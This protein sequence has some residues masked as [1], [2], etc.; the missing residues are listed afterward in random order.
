MTIDEAI[1]KLTAAKNEGV[2]SVVMAYW[3]SNMF[4]REDGAPLPDDKEWEGITEA[5]EYQMDWSRTHDDLSMII[6]Q[7]Y[8][9]A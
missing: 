5:V 8:E 6:E 2:K 7:A 9:E 1:N 3:E 4:Q